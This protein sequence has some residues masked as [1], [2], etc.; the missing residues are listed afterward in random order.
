MR[1]PLSIP[2]RKAQPELSAHGLLL[3]FCWRSSQVTPL[4]QSKNKHLPRSCKVTL[5]LHKMALTYCSSQSISKH[6]ANLQRWQILMNSSIWSTKKKG[7]LEPFFTLLQ[8]ASQRLRASQ[9]I[10]HPNYCSYNNTCKVRNR[11][12]GSSD[13]L[14]LW[15]SWI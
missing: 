14:P 2:H 11:Q 5:H 15:L 3:Q 8:S 13:N 9:Y 12:A 6:S 1:L 4:K 10:K 7:I